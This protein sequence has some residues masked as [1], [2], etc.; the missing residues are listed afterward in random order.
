MPGT[1]TLI[2]CPLIFDFCRRKACDPEHL[3]RGGVTVSGRRTGARKSL[4]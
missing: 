3:R 2:F 4:R 1:T